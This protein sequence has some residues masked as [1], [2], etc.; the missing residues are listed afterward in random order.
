MAQNLFSRPETV[1]ISGGVANAVFSHV[2]IGFEFR[3]ASKVLRE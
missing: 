2:P 3:A 1:A